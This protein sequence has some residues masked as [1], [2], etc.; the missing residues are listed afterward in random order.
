MKTSQLNSRGIPTREN[1][2]S[3]AAF[4][5]AAEELQLEP[6]MGPDDKTAGVFKGGKMHV[7]AGDRFHFRSALTTFRR[8][9]MDEEASNFFKTCLLIERFEG[10]HFLVET[11]RGQFKQARSQ[12]FGSM[13]ISAERVV[14]LWL[15]GVFSHADLKGQNSRIEFERAASTYGAAWLEMVFRTTVQSIGWTA[16]PNLLKVARPTL[17]RWDKDYGVSPEFK[18]GTPFG[19]EV[20]EV[21]DHGWKIVRM[22]STEHLGKETDGQRLRRILARDEFRSLWG[23]INLVGPVEDLLLQAFDSNQTLSGVLETLGARLV[24]KDS[25]NLDAAYS[26]IGKESSPRAVASFHDVSKDLTLPVVVEADG[27]FVTTSE[28]AML[29]EQIYSRFRTQFSI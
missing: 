19:K 24:K 9:W 7:I 27:E 29:F 26:R 11:A 20:E 25:V 4:I 5:E 23:A 14:N 8:I 1:A 15:Y 6:F 13:P 21:D 12:E 3:L 16:V 10:T 17:M 28:A 18:I 2:N 22:A